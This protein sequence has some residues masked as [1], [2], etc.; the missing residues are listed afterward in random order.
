VKKTVVIVVVVLVLLLGVAPWGI[1]RIAEQRVNA[2]LDRFLQE[3]PY[4]SIVERKWTPGWFRSEQTVTVEVLGPWMRAMNPATVLADIEKAE[5]AAAAGKEGAGEPNASAQPL[6]ATPPEASAEAAA[7]PDADAANGAETPAADITPIRFT[8]HN[9]ILHGPV[10]WPASLGFARVN[11]RLVMSDEI[12]KALMEVFG[13]DEPVKL[14]SRVGF[15]G[16]GSA[17]LYGDA[18]TVKMKDEP[19]ELKYDAFELEVGFSKNLDDIDVNGSWPKLE[20][21]NGTNGE[22]L[23]IDGMSF[24]GESERVSIQ[25]AVMLAERW[26]A[27][28]A[29]D[30]SQFLSG[31]DGKESHASANV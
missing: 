6:D 12:R 14:S 15:L 28:T 22:R 18:H 25:A 21:S 20:F 26:T 27:L 9:E 2:G 13:T 17:R 7:A 5:K 3:A 31:E 10:L 4:L 19:G 8:V 29:E 11:T 23:V 24:V 1:G 16:G 30:I